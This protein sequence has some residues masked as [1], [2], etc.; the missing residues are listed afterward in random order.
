MKDFDYDN[1]NPRCPSCK[2][3]QDEDVYYQIIEGKFRA[4]DVTFEN[5]E[6]N[7]KIIPQPILS[8]LQCY[9][10]MKTLDENWIETHY[11]PTCNKEFDYSLPIVEERYEHKEV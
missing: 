2:W 3:T 1:Y 8:R 9:P 10:V 6:G 5:V 11:C 7:Y 4:L